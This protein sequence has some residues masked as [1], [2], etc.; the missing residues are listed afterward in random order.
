MNITALKKALMVFRN[1]NNYGTSYQL[2]MSKR[3]QDGTYL[4]WYEDVR[5]RKD[6]SLEDR[7]M[8]YIKNG[9]RDAY[10]TKKG[11]I[12][13]YFFIDEFETIDK[14][15]EKSKEEHNDAFQQFSEQVVINDDDIPFD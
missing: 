8:I 7:T 13:K 1:D 3:L 2:S 5:F 4:N 12:K 11:E 14:T 6:V 15:I 10:K 9:W